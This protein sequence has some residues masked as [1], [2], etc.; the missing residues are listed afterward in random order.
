MQ[1]V[2]LN[3]CRLAMVGF[4]GML[5]QEHLTGD[6]ALQALLS[7]LGAAADVSLIGSSTALF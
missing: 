7:W 5:V 4:V 6:S 3:H 1:E 2:E